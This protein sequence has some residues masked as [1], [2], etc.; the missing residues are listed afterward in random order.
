MN[1]ELEELQKE[2]YHKQMKLQTAR[3]SRKSAPQSESTRRTQQHYTQRS[4]VS[5]YSE[6]TFPESGDGEL[7]DDEWFEAGMLDDFDSND[8]GQEDNELEEE[9]YNWGDI[10]EAELEQDVA[11]DFMDVDRTVA[12][13][14]IPNRR[15]HA[16]P[17][18]P[19]PVLGQ[20]RRNFSR[21]DSRKLPVSSL[22]VNRPDYS[23]S[24]PC[25]SN[26]PRKRPGESIF[27]APKPQASR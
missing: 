13:Q 18:P 2:C 20:N 21:T 22:E 14:S 9:Y 12:P 15:T 26:V 7:V 27:K 5:N 8:E 1:K 24:S 4:Q 3:Q 11:D 10:D 16:S 23:L 25:P 6:E 17:P 19:A